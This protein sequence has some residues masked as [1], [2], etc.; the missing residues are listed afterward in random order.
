VEEDR[1][2][3]ATLASEEVRQE[4]KVRAKVQR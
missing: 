4:E 2:D 1:K 3:W